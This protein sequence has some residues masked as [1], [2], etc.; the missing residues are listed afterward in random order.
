MAFVAAPTNTYVSVADNQISYDTVNF[1]ETGY[2]KFA[3]AQ[4]IYDTKVYYGP[5]VQRTH[6]VITFKN[7]T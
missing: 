3:D 1:M 2:Q 4:S 7:Q 6:K 5:G